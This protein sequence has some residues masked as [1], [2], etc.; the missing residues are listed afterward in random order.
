MLVAILSAQRTRT[1][2]K[3]SLE[4]ICISPGK[5]T[6][7]ASS[8]LKQTSAT[9]DQKRHLFPHLFSSFNLDRRLCVVELLKGYI[10]KTAPPRKGTNYIQLYTATADLL[11]STTWHGPAFKAT[12]SSWIK[13]SMKATRID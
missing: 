1:L 5:Y 3:L 11:F 13:Q 12:N 8:L 10:K 4:K 7:Y 2:Q 9:G 6:F